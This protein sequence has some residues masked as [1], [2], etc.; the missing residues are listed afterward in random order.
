MAGTTFCRLSN[1]C[2]L[3]FGGGVAVWAYLA[4]GCCPFTLDVSSWQVSFME[5]IDC[6]LLSQAQGQ[7]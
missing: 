4:V 6:V 3:Q 5:M 2:D 1:R 7:G